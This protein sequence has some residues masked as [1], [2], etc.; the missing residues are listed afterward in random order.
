MGIC[1]SKN[2][3]SA[4]TGLAEMTASSDGGAPLSLEPGEELPMP[5]GPLVPFLRGEGPDDSGRTLEEILS[6]ND[7]MMERVHNYVQWIFPTDEQS[8]FNYGAP[9]MTPE[10]QRFCRQDPVILANFDKTL[11]RFLAFLGLEMHGEPGKLRVSRAAFFD[12]RVPDCWVS[13]GGMGNHNW[14]R[15]SRVLHCLGMIGKKEQQQ[16]LLAC[17]EE[18][19]KGGLQVRSALPHW[20]ERA[21]V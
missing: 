6:W 12:S 19:H 2:A 3:Q 7:N 17:L 11:T 1:R 20:R 15:I 16:A 14:L 21:K 4:K 18:M 8:K 5:R 13:M 10:V 9:L